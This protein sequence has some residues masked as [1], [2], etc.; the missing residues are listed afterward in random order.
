MN[1]KSSE[2]HDLARQLA[3]LED[4][5]VTNAVT[6]SLREALARRQAD[7]ITKNRLA[8]M[9]PLAD[10]FADLERQDPGARSPWEINADLYNEHGLPR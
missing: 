5:T 4:T 3:A 7:Q 1:I 10:T 2:A 6:M 9:R 8:K